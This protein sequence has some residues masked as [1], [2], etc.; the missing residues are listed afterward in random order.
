MGESIVMV[1]Q[2]KNNES[3]GQKH[4]LFFTKIKQMKK[5]YLNKWNQDVKF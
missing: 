5:K 1:M 4:H 2:P 3:K